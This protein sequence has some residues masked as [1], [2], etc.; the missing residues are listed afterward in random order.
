ML[1]DPEKVRLWLGLSEDWDNEENPQEGLS[2]AKATSATLAMTVSDEE[3]AKAVI[4]E[5]VS[6]TIVCLLQSENKDLIH[7]TL[8]IIVSLVQCLG[9]TAAS[10][11]LE[12]GV[13]PAISI[14]LKLGDENLASLA[15]DAAQELSKAMKNTESS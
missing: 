3:V 14:V 9:N 10:H 4:Q 2:I 1:R 12:G 5:N 7:R 15:R 8:V 13:V 6:K 11:L